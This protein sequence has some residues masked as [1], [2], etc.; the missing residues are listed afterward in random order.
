MTHSPVPAPQTDLTEAEAVIRLL[1][2]AL[3]EVLQEH[4]ET[5]TSGESRAVAHRQ[6]H[7]AAL[8]LTR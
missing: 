2:D 7:L 1:M 5:L 4:P 8:F 3:V 6:L